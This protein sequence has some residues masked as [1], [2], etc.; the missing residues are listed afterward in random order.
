MTI[1]LT[2]NGSPTTFAGDSDMPLLWFLREA[3]DIHSPK[4]GCGAGLC[5]ACTVHVDG[6]AT[7]SCQFP[8]ALASGV[9]VTTL[10]GIGK[11]DALHPVQIAW[12][13]F[14]VPQCGYCQPGQIMAAVD[15]LA[16]KPAPTDQDIDAEMTNI[17][18]CG[19]YPDIRRAIHRAAK[20]LAEP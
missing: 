5:G 1:K 17:C 2:V 9:Q 15:M 8:M 19:T 11:P 3:M 18:R 7:R 4:F 12:L 13:D 14:D 10:E 20:L 16:R 6:T